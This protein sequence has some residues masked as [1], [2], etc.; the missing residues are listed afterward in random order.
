M[1]EVGFL[2]FVWVRNYLVFS[3]KYDIVFLSNYFM[4][5]KVVMCNKFFMMLI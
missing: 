2:S 5:E 4:G 3:N 1:N